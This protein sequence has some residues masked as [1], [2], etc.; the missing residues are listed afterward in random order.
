MGTTF[1]PLERILSLSVAAGIALGLLQG[2]AHAGD[3]VPGISISFVGYTNSTA[4]VTLAL[5][6]VYFISPRLSDQLRNYTNQEEFYRA[7]VCKNPEYMRFNQVFEMTNPP[8]YAVFK[9]ANRGAENF[10]WSA[11]TM[12]AWSREQAAVDKASLR[13]CEGVERTAY[14][15]LSGG[16]EKLV[17]V[18]V[19]RECSHWQCEFTFCGIGPHELG[20]KTLLGPDTTSK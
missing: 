13:N 14:S 9:V 4:G 20:C 8:Q 18:Q 12:F 1:K 2:A 17:A 19:P 3:E 16:E 5:C 15:S 11:P 6:P 10:F 7:V